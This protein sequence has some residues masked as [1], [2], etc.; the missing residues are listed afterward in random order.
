MSALGFVET[1]RLAKRRDIYFVGDF[2]MTLDRLDRLGSFVEIA[3]M[4]DN[5]DSLP[6]WAE[7]VEA[8]A[9]KLGL[10]S[11]QIETRSYRAM[12]MAETGA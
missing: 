2:H 11:P 8:I 6:A 7:R 4:T 12:M 5:A 9:G 10:A 1:G 3:V